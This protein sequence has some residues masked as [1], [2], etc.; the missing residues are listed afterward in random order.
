MFWSTGFVFNYDYIDSG[1]LI[2]APW[3]ETLALS[4]FVY[5]KELGFETDALVSH[6]GKF[7]IGLLTNPNDDIKYMS[8]QYAA[9]VANDSATN[10]Y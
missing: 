8:S 7:M 6:M 2:I 4:G 9:A 3:Q 5:A 10:K 1:S